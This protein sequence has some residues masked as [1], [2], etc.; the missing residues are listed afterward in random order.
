[1]LPTM[2]AILSLWLVL[3]CSATLLGQSSSR[4]RQIDSLRAELDRPQQDT[5]RYALLTK[6][7]FLYYDDSLPDSAIAIAERAKAI[8]HLLGDAVRI[9]DACFLIGTTYRAQLATYDKGLEYFFL[10]LTHLENARSHPKYLVKRARLLTEIA[11]SY[12]SLEDFEQAIAYCIEI[13]Q[14]ARENGFKFYEAIAAAT[15]SSIRRLMGDYDAA[16]VLTERTLVLRR[17]IGDSAVV[18]RSI[19]TVGEILY[20]KGKPLDA[21]PQLF[22][23]LEMLNGEIH[24]TVRAYNNIARCYLAIHML[25]SAAI[26]AQKGYDLSVSTRRKFGLQQ[27]YKIMADIKERQGQFEEALFFQKRYNELRDTVLSGQRRQRAAA[28]QMRAAIEEKER[29]Q[30]KALKQQFIV[31]NVLLSILGVLTAAMFVVALAYRQKQKS[32]QALQEKNALIEKQNRQLETQRD[33]L[34]EA[35]KLKSELLAIAAHDLKNPLQSIVGFASLIEEKVEPQ[36]EFAQMSR[37]I[38]QSADKML[39]LIND[40][41]DTTVM[42]MGRMKLRK[43]SIDISELIED[44]VNDHLASAQRK[45]QTIEVTT[46]RDVIVS[47]DEERMR[48]VLSNLISNAIK[49]SPTGKTI[50]V[51]TKKTGIRRQDTEGISTLPPSDSCILISVRDEGKGLTES[52]KA[53]LFQQFQRLSAQ[54]TGGESSTGL[55]LW[56]AKEIVEL[57]GGKIW[58]ES[59]GN[60]STFFVELPALP[61]AKPISV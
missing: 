33:D 42:Q 22:K 5:T 23:S 20:L 27:C 8:A 58:A 7:G 46:D 6:L 44:V 18:A 37:F 30:E 15:E 57:H 35:N 25:D 51:E 31:Q 41:L 34:A 52:D 32:E 48:Q 26:Y 45:N 16:M 54:P 53:K 17:E 28:L 14:I 39:R 59:K 38:K 11:L 19:G 55:G 50:Y 12:E 2:R 56:I 47:V 61:V 9:S 40:L 1:M 36:S 24:N 4:Q 29:E 49:Y 13:R 21:L 10:G 60:G 3:A 43:A